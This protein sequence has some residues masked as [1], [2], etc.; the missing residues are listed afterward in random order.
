MAVVAARRSGFT[1]WAAWVAA[2]AVGTAVAA[3]VPVSTVPFISAQGLLGYLTTAILEAPVILLQYLVL[4]AIANASRA[5]GALWIVASLIGGIAYSVASAILFAQV[6][7]R[8]VSPSQLDALFAVQEY[9]FPF[10]VGLAQGAVLARSWRRYPV[11]IIW[12]LA[13]LFAFRVTFSVTPLLLNPADTPQV[14]EAVLFWTVY[15]VVTGVALV[16]IT[17]RRPATAPAPAAR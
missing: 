12:V 11:A 13:N 6:V 2:A 17:L 14:L 15:A 8:L 1:L 3:S 4:R 7:P 5:A 9:S 10:L 16:G